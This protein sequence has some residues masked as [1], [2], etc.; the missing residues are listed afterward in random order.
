MFAK[1]NVFALNN[2]I[3]SGQNGDGQSYTIYNTRRQD[4]SVFASTTLGYKN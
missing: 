1:A 2:L 4:Q 3:W